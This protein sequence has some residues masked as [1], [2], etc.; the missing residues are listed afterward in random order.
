MH[1]VLSGGLSRSRRRR[2]LWLLVVCLTAVALPLVFWLRHPHGGGTARAD[3]GQVNPA[4]SATG[5]AARCPGPD[6]QGVGDGATD[7]RAV[8]DSWRKVVGPVYRAA[9]ER[10]YGALSRLL[11]AG[12]VKDF[13]TDDCAGCTG[14]DVVAM[15]RDEY[16]I[17]GA[18]LARLLTTP[19]VAD[20][21]GLT[22]ASGDALAVFGRGTHD[23]PPQWS[24]FYPDC[25]SH[26][27]CQQMLDVVRRTG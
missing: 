24:A 2:V 15:W 23:V 21:G 20:Q 27:A 13:L 10:D 18:D 12:S 22:Y 25:R 3:G 8:E 7:P 14:Q 6:V 19:P 17:D 5:P 16:D 11:A 4:A 1:T 9:C 26:R